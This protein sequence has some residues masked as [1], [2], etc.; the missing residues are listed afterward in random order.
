MPGIKDPQD[1]ETSASV[2]LPPAQ[3]QKI[4][5]L[6]GGGVGQSNSATARTALIDVAAPNP[7]WV[8][9]PS[10]AEPTRYPITVLLPS[11]Q[12]LVTGGSAVLPRHARQRQPGHPDL[13]RGQ[14]HV[15]L[16]RE[17]DHRP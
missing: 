15:L 10:L 7:Q 2:L 1:L 9:G 4:M 12:V 3:N 6:G 17:L 14:Q 5:V 8:T 11:D 13:Q 16:G